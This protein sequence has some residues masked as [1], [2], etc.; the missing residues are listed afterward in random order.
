MQA[1]ADDDM[2]IY[3]VPP[4][5]K[6]PVAINVRVEPDLRDG[7]EDVV[8]LWKVMAEARGDEASVVELSYVA[9]RLWAVGVDQAFG[10]VGGRPRDEAGWAKLE[11]EIRKAA[12]SQKKNR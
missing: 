12:P 3:E 8:R 1:A 4:A 7:L 5:K 2:A 9:R 11:A 6:P 10:E